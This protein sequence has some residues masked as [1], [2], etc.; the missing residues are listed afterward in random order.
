MKIKFKFDYII[1][2]LVLIIAYSIFRNYQ[3]DRD[4]EVEFLRQEIKTQTLRQAT[5]VSM[6]QQREMA[7][8]PPVTPTAP[9]AMPDQATPT[10]PAAMPDQATPTAPAAMPD[11]ATP[12]PPAAMP[13]QAT[14]TPP[15]AM[16]D[17]ATP[18]APAAL[19]APTIAPIQAR[20]PAPAIQRAPML[21]ATDIGPASIADVWPAIKQI[22]VD[23]G[24]WD[25]ALLAIQIIAVVIIIFSLLNWLK[26]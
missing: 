12:T 11:Q 1:I 20:S 16:P 4:K 21:G 25:F 5:I 6:L 22:L 26:P 2:L 7:E 19:A 10:A 23:L 15:A 3:T 8:Q 9:A 17:Q 14:P 24:I 18:T 13:D